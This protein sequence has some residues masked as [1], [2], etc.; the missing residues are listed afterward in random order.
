[1]GR[2]PD[3][4]RARAVAEQLALS[5][6]SPNSSSPGQF[7]GNDFEGSA[8]RLA[9]ISYK[10]PEEIGKARHLELP[11]TGQGL[12][13][14]VSILERILSCSINTRHQGFMHK[15]YASTNAVG[16]ISELILAVLNTNVF[17]PMLL[18]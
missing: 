1:V 3:F 10:S 7:L 18:N 12:G 8:G 4:V 6:Q 11:T 5:N 9:P 17:V 15:L 14:L 2:F 16:V 13:G